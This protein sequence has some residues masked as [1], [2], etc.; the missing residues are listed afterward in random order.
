MERFSSSTVVACASI[1]AT[2]NGRSTLMSC[3][4]SRAN[5]IAVNG[6]RIVPARIA[7]MLINGQ[8]PAPSC[9]RNMAST[10]PNA[11]PIIS[12]GASTPPD[13]P[14]PSEMIQMAD[15]TSSTPAITARG[16]SPC[17]RDWIVS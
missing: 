15:F 16:T 4:S 14:E 10:P 12:K 8:K 17:S 13:V 3:V 9:G 7:P 6:A 2:S 11:A 5:R 1:A